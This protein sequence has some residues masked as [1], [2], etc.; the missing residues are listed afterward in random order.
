MAP[1]KDKVIINLGCGNK[2]LAEEIGVDIIDGPLVDVVTDLNQYPLPFDDN[3]VDI[4]RS[5]HC[6]EH[7]DNIVTLMDDLVM[8]GLV[9]SGDVRTLF[10]EC[11]LF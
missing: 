11:T 3:S 6:F 10:R 9:E 1:N 7:L 8:G 4:V 5:S 2:K